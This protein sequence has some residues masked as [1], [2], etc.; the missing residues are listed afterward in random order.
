[1]KISELATQYMAVLPL[2]CV[3]TDDQVQRN[4]RTAVRFYCGFADL[5]SEEAVNGQAL[6]GSDEAQDVTLSHGELALIRPLWDLYMERENSMALEAS[7]SQGAELFGRTVAEVQMSIQEYEMRL[8]QLA[9]CEDWM[10]I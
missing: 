5:V 3:L 7:R 6:I 8:P 1:M 4:L 9:F 2:G 10:T